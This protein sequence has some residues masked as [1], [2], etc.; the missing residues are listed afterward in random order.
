MNTTIMSGTWLEHHMEM[1]NLTSRFPVPHY[2]AKYQLV[3]FKLH[4]NRNNK[5]QWVIVGVDFPF[6]C[7]SGECQTICNYLRFAASIFVVYGAG[8]E[9]AIGK[10]FANIYQWYGLGG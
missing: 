4:A 1:K 9:N 8:K 3:T 10:S 5:P 7:T 2:D 6:L